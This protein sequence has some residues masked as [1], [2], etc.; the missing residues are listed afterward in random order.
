[1]SQHT[2]NV[3]PA[4]GRQLKELRKEQGLSLRRLGRIIHVSHSFLW[5]IEAV[6]KRPSAEVAKLLDA[7]L[8]AGGQLYAMVPKVS[9]DSGVHPV[10]TE[11]NAQPANVGLEFAPDWRH[12]LDIALELWR[13]DMRRRNVLRGVGFSASVFLSPAMRWLSSPLDERPTG[14]GDRLV[15]LPDVET[16][17][18]ITSTYRTLD[19]QYGGG[20][21]RDSVIRFL[22]NDV[23]EL[24]NGRYDPGTGRALF[25]AVAEATQLAAWTSYDAGM[26]GLAQRYMIQSLRFATAAADRAL[27]AEILAAMSHQA[28]YMGASAEAVDLALAAG[29]TA[30]DAGM[31]AIQAEAAVLEAQGYAVGS[32]E[33]ACTAA[34]NRA[35][36]IFNKAERASDPQWIGYFDEA[37]LA[38]KFGHC[39]TALGR[40]DIAQ[41]FAA[42]SL[43]MDGKNYAR[44]RQFNLVLL[45]VAHVQDKEPEESARFGMKALDAVE[46]LHSSRAR[47]YLADLAN[48]LA[49]HVGLP[50]VREFTERARLVLQAD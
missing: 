11:V 43:K 46:G 36:K 34:L 8:S 44:G 10:G 13:E 14:S 41:R 9:A 12:G 22:G 49:P 38:A 24:L 26:H 16:V 32:N 31:A 47:D 25:S 4:F 29:R 20:H 19:N 39:F 33:N 7:A 40:G 50:P 45:A 18:R 48:R 17:R 6:R 30:K 1:M 42:R 2:D 37:Y 27:G 35:E 23:V 15:G 28:A 21:I 3:D 5:E